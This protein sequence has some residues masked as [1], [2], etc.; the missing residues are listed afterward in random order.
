[1]Y[2]DS[3]NDSWF[4]HTSASSHQ[5][6][7]VHGVLKYHVLLQPPGSPCRVTRRYVKILWLMVQ[8]EHFVVV[9]VINQRLDTNFLLR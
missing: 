5:V 2:I 1:M 4:L 3:R 9:A 6:F 8:E 7:Y